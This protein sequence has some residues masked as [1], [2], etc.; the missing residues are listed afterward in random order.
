LICQGRHYA[1]ERVAA[2]WRTPTEKC[3]RVCTPDGSSFDL[4]YDLF[5]DEWRIIQQ[6]HGI[7][8]PDTRMNRTITGEQNQ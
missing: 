5:E 8:D 2:E 4:I 6:A 1:V 7:T 3:F